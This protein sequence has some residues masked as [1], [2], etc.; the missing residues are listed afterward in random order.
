MKKCPYCGISYD[1]ATNFCSSCGTR[2]AIVSSK[3]SAP[4][5]HRKIKRKQKRRLGIPIVILIIALF[6]VFIFVYR[7]EYKPLIID[8]NPSVYTYED[9]VSDTNLLKSRYF[10]VFSADSLGETADGRQVLHFVIGNEDASRKILIN[11]G[12]HAREYITC[13]LVMKQTVMFLKHLKHG[14]SYGDISYKDLLRNTAIHVICMVNPDGVSISQQ[15]LDGVQ[16]DAVRKNL[17]QI[18]QMDGASLS[19]KDYLI[20]WKSNANGVDLN[21]NFDALWDS[22]ADPAGHPS[23]DHYKGT[24]PG[25]EAESNALIQLTLQEQFSRTIS[26]HTQGDVIYWYFGQDGDLYDQTLAFA[27]TIAATTGYPLD[28]DYQSLDPAGYKDWAIQSQ[29]IPSLTIEVGTGDTP[30]SP[31]QFETIWE[32]NQF[33]WEETLKTL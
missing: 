15:G 18:A 1:D 9:L 22:Y 7:K 3:K 21:R 4:S 19:D 13:Q 20:Q 17:E 30:V 28:A 14:D 2:L 31:G 24:A 16:T 23:A 8:Q 27:N 10:S 12:I 5:G 25:C 33:V 29:G 26:Y 6:I 11:G 32:E